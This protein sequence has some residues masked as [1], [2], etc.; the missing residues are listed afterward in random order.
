MCFKSIGVDY[1]TLKARSTEQR[2]F[3]LFSWSFSQS[4]GE[5]LHKYR[6]DASYLHCVSLYGNL[7]LLT[8]VRHVTVDKLLWSLMQSWVKFVLVV[9]LVA[10]FCLFSFRSE[11]SMGFWLRSDAVTKLPVLCVAVRAVACRFSDGREMLRTHKWEIS[12]T[13]KWWICCAKAEHNFTN[14]WYIHRYC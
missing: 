3:C 7:K 11:K 8:A 5:L 12:W 14:L 6:L 10:L 9:V 4:L 13:C 1:S 2:S